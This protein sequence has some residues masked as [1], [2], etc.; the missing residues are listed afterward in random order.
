MAYDWTDRMGAANPVPELEPYYRAAIK[1]ATEYLERATAEGTEI[2]EFSGGQFASPRNGA[3]N[4]VAAAI[5][6][7][8]ERL[9]GGPE[10]QP[11]GSV[12]MAIVTFA[13]RGAFAVREGGFGEAGWAHFASKLALPPRRPRAPGTRPSR[14]IRSEPTPAPAPDPDPTPA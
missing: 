6:A 13:V 1:I 9:A 3:A 2:P 10:G 5:A 7:E 14:P 4:E 11:Q 8:I 12:S